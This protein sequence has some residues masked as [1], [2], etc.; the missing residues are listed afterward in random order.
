[1]AWQQRPE[2]RTA[3]LRALPPRVTGRCAAA[4]AGWA[5][6]PTATR[7]EVGARLASTGALRS[8]DAVL[9]LVAQHGTLAHVVTVRPDDPKRLCLLYLLHW[10]PPTRQHV[11]ASLG[12]GRDL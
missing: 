9:R 2:L 12:T 5:K 6:L 10:P 1:M 4:A 8:L 11:R 7:A 3:T